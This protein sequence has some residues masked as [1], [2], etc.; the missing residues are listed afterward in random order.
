SKDVIKAEGGW[1]DDLSTE[2]VQFPLLIEMNQMGYLEVISN[3]PLNKQLFENFAM[4]LTRSITIHN[5][6][7]QRQQLALLEERAVIARELHDSIGQLLS[8]LKIQ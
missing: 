4:M 6:S 5:A 7:E 1:P 8:F 2:S 3:K